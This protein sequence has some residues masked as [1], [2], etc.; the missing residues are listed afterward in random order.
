LR[1]FLSSPH[2]SHHLDIVDILDAI[3]MF[4]AERSGTREDYF[5]FISLASSKRFHK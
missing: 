3:E 5:H 4:S 1:L 2:Q